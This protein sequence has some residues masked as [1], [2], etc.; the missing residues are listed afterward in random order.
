MLHEKCSTNN[1]RDGFTRGVPKIE[2]KNNQLTSVPISTN[3]RVRRR[4][5]PSDTGARMPSA[6]CRILRAY[7]SHSPAAMLG[8]RESKGT[9]AQKTLQY[10]RTL[11][12]AMKSSTCSQKTAQKTRTF[13]KETP[14]RDLFTWD[15]SP[16]HISR[17]LRQEL[18]LLAIDS[19]HPVPRGKRMPKQLKHCIH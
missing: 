3:A 19:M 6:A 16:C 5:H 13:L 17:N 18:H 10:I 1:R 4:K 12:E 8:L 9:N 7:P 14:G 15:A 11:Q 2:E